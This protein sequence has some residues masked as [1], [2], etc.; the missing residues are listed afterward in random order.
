MTNSE[1]KNR[2]IIIIMIDTDL[3]YSVFYL[4]KDQIF[5]IYIKNI[6]Y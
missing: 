6:Q 3:Y 1:P 2:N 5:A 4:K